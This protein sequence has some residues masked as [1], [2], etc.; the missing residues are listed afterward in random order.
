MRSAP[1]LDPLDAD[2]VADVLLIAPTDVDTVSC[3]KTTVDAPAVRKP[4]VSTDDVALTAEPVV[5]SLSYPTATEAVEVT[6]AD[7][8]NVTRPDAVTEAEALTVADAS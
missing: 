2:D 1:Q 6:D 4:K 7:P 3:G 5:R 8:I